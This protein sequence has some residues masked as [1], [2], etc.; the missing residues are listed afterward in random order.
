MNLF[1][2]YMQTI[3]V[4]RIEKSV[5]SLIMS[6]IFL[7]LPTPFLYTLEKVTNLMD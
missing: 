4:I 2:Y 3:L 7:P 6:K 5:L 1:I